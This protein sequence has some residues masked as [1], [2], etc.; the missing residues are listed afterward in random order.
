MFV[1]LIITEVS[2]N[3]NKIGLIFGVCNLGILNTTL[4][5]IDIISYINKN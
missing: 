1:P 3:T 5:K 2:D 4:A